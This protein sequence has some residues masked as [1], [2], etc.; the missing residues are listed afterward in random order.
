M[1]SGGIK[2]GIRQIIVSILGKEHYSKIKSLLKKE[3]YNLHG[4]E[5]HLVEHCNL[6]CWGCNH[7]SPLAEKE[8]LQI[9]TFEQDIK[10]I[11]K[12]TNRKINYLHLTGGEPLLHPDITDF[13][14]ISRKYFPVAKINLFTN[15]TLIL[16]QKE[17][18]WRN[19]RKYNIT[20]LATKYPILHWEN[21]ENKIIENKI[22]FEYTIPEDSLKETWFRPLD[23]TGS[24]DKYESFMRC[25]GDKCTFLYYGRLYNCPVSANVRH[26]AKYF[27]IDVKITSE[28]S[29]D[30][31]KANNVKEI[32]DFLARPKSVCRYC[33]VNRYYEM[34]WKMTE[35]KMNEWV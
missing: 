1:I 8:F 20:I 27:G 11:S 23:L 6:G 28:D 4:F 5:V 24:Q 12:L 15:G 7:Y 29:I 13:F 2:Q 35:R 25:R 19:M 9:E 16:K 31:Y 34:P 21:I 22:K 26:F 30:I 18:F 32:L 17:H 3:K 33:D 10:R 14:R